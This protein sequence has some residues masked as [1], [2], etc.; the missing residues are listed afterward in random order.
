MV[1]E[2]KLMEVEK[3]LREFVEANNKELELI[4]LNDVAILFYGLPKNMFDLIF[5]A[6]IVKGDLFRLYEFLASKGI[7]ADLSENIGGWSVIGMP[8][9]Y[10]DRA[11]T[12]YEDEKLRIKLLNPY[13]F[14]VAKLRRGT[15]EDIKDAIAVFRKFKL[16]TKELDRYIE[17]AIAN[18]IKD[19]SILAFKKRYNKFKEILQK[20]E[21]QHENNPYPDWGRF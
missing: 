14:I 8:E 17:S 13:D 6:E 7:P 2:S 10:R 5:C 11:Y 19:T 15:H 4:L 3:V 12:V 20:K 16:S 21:R 9:G 18:S 1:T